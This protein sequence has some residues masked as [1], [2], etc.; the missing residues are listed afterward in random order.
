MKI[1]SRQQSLSKQ[2]LI[3]FGLSLMT[4]GL[5]TLSI[6]YRLIQADL[7]HKVLE[8]AHSVT[9]S[10]GFAATKLL[11]QQTLEPLQQVVQNYAT[12]PTVQ[13]VAIVS[14]QGAVLA[15][16]STIWQNRQLYQIHPKL[17]SLVADA[18]RQSS[19]LTRP[20]RFN[21]QSVLLHITPL[22][23]AAGQRTLVIAILDRQKIRESAQ[24][25]LLASS[26]TLVLGTTAILG[27]M[28]LL[29]QRLV[30][31]PLDQLSQ[32]IKV[33][34][35]TGLFQLPLLPSNNEIAALA[36]TFH[37]VF[38]Q[39]QQSEK[40]LAESEKRF[41]TLV[42]NT[43]G[44][45]YRCAFDSQWSMDFIS[46]AIM[47]ISGYPA[48]TIIHNRV[49]S[50][51]S[52]IHP[53]D[54]VS[55]EREVARCIE[56]RQ[57]YLLE[58]RIVHADG[59]IHWVRE[60][61]Q[62]VFDAEGT[63]LHL[64]GVIFDISSLKQVEAALRQSEERLRTV[65]RAAPILLFA[66]DAS[67]QLTFAD[68]CGLAL[69]NL[70]PD[71]LVGTSVYDLYRRSPE[72]LQQIQQA[73]QGAEVTGTVEIEDI[74]FESRYRPVRDTAGTVTGVIGVSIDMTDRKR[75]EAQLQQKTAAL[76]QALLEL[77]RTQLQMVQSEKMSSLG[78]MVAGIAHEIN[79]PV[80]FIH[81]NLNHI[82]CYA[83][84]LLELI[85]LYQQHLPEPPPAIAAHIDAI[86]L[87]FLSQD[88]TKALQSMQTGT[89][90]IREIVLSLR[91]FS[92]IDEAEVKEVDIHEGIDN[93]LTILGH[94]LKA[95]PHRSEIRVV[96]DYQPLP[97]VECYPG[98]LNQVFMN[99]LANAI[100][101]LEATFPQAAG[102]ACL[103]LPSGEPAT[104]WITTSV[105][106][107]DRVAIHIRDNGEGIP[108]SVRR[109]LFDPFFTTKPVGKGTGLGLSISYQI[110]TERH[111][112]ELYCHSTPG[113]GA[114]FVIVIPV[115]QTFSEAFSD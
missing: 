115:K 5:T 17:A 13:T 12:L 80:N 65:I 90:R 22:R 38:Q 41:R 92:R 85:V 21:G 67:G 68:G 100:D 102:T 9:V 61:G 77:Q 75:A 11:E 28:W 4:L 87:E 105:R 53:D 6:N 64:D 45:I 107:H 78:Q 74:F 103:T 3:R 82:S 39:R 89:N 7:E 63:L 62:G 16:S 55:V 81:G 97:L 36:E 47:D 10:L 32:E 43:P 112:G 109:R 101:A 60:R 88:L 25:T 96:R 56:Q 104:I 66:I 35:A 23:P 14:D 72:A 54:T 15:S 113:Q 29:L 27:L 58:Y 83:Q 2:L 106:N 34:Q 40:I 108:D 98:P 91:N 76:E 19:S 46:D 33:S 52:L 51:A 70:E 1:A 26:A 59:S 31:H 69:L 57:P 20:L 42:E 48:S 84:E 8:Q 37:A 95:K 94:R 44:A 18:V 50:F 30:L 111:G 99:I 93:T 86:D 79:N 73:L 49:R 110:I 71:A 24:H 114:E